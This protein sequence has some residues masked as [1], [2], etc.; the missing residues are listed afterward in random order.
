[1]QTDQ[2]LEKLLFWT[3]TPRISVSEI[4]RFPIKSHPFPINKWILKSKQKLFSCFLH[5]QFR[6]HLFLSSCHM[7][8]PKVLGRISTQKAT[9]VCTCISTPYILKGRMI[10]GAAFNALF[11]LGPKTKDA[12]S[13]EG[14]DGQNA[15]TRTSRNIDNKKYCCPRLNRASALLTAAGKQ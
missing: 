10:L 13:Q 4:L 14:R 1:M 6:G 8:L 5:L 2:S 7:D 3:T 9:G 12:A 15:A 11:S